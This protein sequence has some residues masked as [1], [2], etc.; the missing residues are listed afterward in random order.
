MGKYQVAMVFLTAVIL[1]ASSTT[2][3]H[4][5]ETNMI[6]ALAN[7]FFLFGFKVVVGF[8]LLPVRIPRKINRIILFGC[9]F[10]LSLITSFTLNQIAPSY[11][12]LWI[13]LQQLFIFHGM[14]GIL[15]NGSLMAVL[16]LLPG[17][18]YILV[19]M[20]S[21]FFTTCS[22]WLETNFTGPINNSPGSWLVVFSIHILP[23]IFNSIL[24]LYLT[25]HSDRITI[26]KKRRTII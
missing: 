22:G 20:G 25:H 5:T 11:Y 7:V 14:T 19:V 9:W 26:P 16:R 8:Y 4:L 17:P 3:F 13:V 24:I 6:L 21:L 10:L 2:I 18:F 1:A 23:F 12:L 15:W